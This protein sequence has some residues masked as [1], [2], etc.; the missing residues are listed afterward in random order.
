[1]KLEALRDCIVL[2]PIL[3]DTKTVTKGGIV[4]PNGYS[5]KFEDGAEVI[6]V[7]PLVENLAAGDIVIRPEPERREITDDNTGEVFWLSAEE[8]ILA[9]VIDG[10]IKDEVYEDYSGLLGNN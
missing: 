4:M 7:G 9:K 1:M 2:R 8:D 3:A 6:S 10:K 5:D